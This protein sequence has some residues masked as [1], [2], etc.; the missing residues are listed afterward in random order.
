MTVPVIVAVAGVSVTILLWQV[1]I[2]SNQRN[3]EQ[4]F[5]LA[6]QHRSDAIERELRAHLAAVAML[7]GL[8]GA[9]N[10]IDTTVF[11]DVSRAALDANA[12]AIQ[13][14]EWIP[15]VT[16][17]EREASEAGMERVYS[18]FG[19]RERDADGLFVSARD[20]AE[21]FPVTLVEP[22]EGNEAAVGFDLA[23]NPARLETLER[24][25]D[26]GAL[27]V[28]RRIRLVQETGGFLA[29][30]KAEDGLKRIP[31]VVLTTAKADEDVLASYDLHANCYINKPVD[32]EQFMR[33]VKSIEDFWLT[34]VRL[35][36]E[37]AA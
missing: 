24:A 10:A 34:V 27:V 1:R 7:G 25:R 3:L 21:Y 23:S 22:L 32:L 33:V 16:D 2:D 13:A 26:T 18:G 30:I 19:I 5:D 37:A 20:R 12:G 36:S 28:T 31:V 17:A 6:T 29:E 35:P 15:R 8:R 4:H 9:E 11:A 14:L